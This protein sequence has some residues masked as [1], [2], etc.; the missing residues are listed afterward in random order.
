MRFSYILFLFISISTLAQTPLYEYVNMEYTS[1]IPTNLNNSRS[2]V[3]IN[4]PNKKGE[5]TELGDWKALASAAYSGFVKMKLDAIFCVNQVDLQSSTS[6]YETFVETFNKRRIKNLIF[7]TQNKNG[8]EII[9]T[10]FKGTS[11]LLSN[12]QTAYRVS[13]EK[14]KD[15]LLSLGREIRRAELEQGNFL[16]PDKPS[17]LSGK[18]IIEKT[19]LKNY[20]GQLRRSVLAV[21]RFS[22]MPDSDGNEEVSNKI[23]AYNAAIDLKNQE[24]DSIMKSY[25]YKYVMVDPMS[26]EE[27][28]RNRHQ[29]I[30]RSITGS[31][32]G[33]RKM[34]EFDVVPSETDFVSMIPI[35]P[36][37]TTIKT[38]PRNAIV[39]KFYVKQNISKNVHVGEWDADDTW[40][41]ALKNMIGNLSQRLVIKK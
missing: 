7:V 5:F 38:I 3:I 4:M 31:T 1:D 13:S 30:L 14:L 20:P 9:V 27:L 36:D 2:A 21:E 32:S 25:P 12:N 22:K 19:Q 26:D 15:A 24:L 29:F 11:S 10:A 37:R 18:S 35:M 16:I 39:T 6:S 33:V 34:L 23:S 40:Q 41:A 17:F 28:L 8:F